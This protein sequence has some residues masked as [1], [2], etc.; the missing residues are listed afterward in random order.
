MRFSLTALAV[1][2]A[3]LAA[4]SAFAQ[5]QADLEND[6]STPGDVLTYGMGYDLTRHSAMTQINKE[7]VKRLVPAW[8]YSLAD[9]RGQE[10]FP[11]VHNGVMYATTHNAT[12][13]IDA[14]TGA[15]KWKTAVE[16]PAETPRVACC[17][18]VNRGAAIKDGKL[19]RTT[20]DA[21]ITAL[22]METGAELWKTKSIDSKRAIPSRSPR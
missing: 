13:A 10:T 16:Y 6:V 8:S 1:S 17:G 12:V 14:L 5:S 21:H 4:P 22:D 18:I 19:I 9:S 20:L 7:T 15:Q 3:L 2:A 11:L